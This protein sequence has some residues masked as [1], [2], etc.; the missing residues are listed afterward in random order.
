M[1][2]APG[3]PQ[4]EYRFQRMKDV[5]QK[6]DPL[7]ASAAQAT[8]RRQSASAEWTERTESG[9]ARSRSFNV[10]E[11]RFSVRSSAEEP[12]S[13]IEED[14]KFFATKEPGHGVVIELIAE[15]PPLDTVPASDAVV[16]TPRNVVYREGGKRFIDYHRRALAIQNEATGDLRIYS[17]DNGML[18]EAAYLYLLSQIGQRLDAAGLHRIHA[19]GLVVKRRAVLVMLPMGG[20]K[21]TLGLQLL[22]HP[23]VELLSDDAPFVDRRGRLLACPLRLGLLPGSEKTIPAE[24]RR[25]IQRMEFGPKH[26]VNYS[27]FSSRVCPSAEPGRCSLAHAPWPHPAGSKRSAVSP[28]CEPV[29]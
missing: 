14:F 12:L 26:L 11:Y 4:S 9:T 18:Y 22:Q 21:S 3:L 25:T 24:Q 15:A 23:Q 28:P 27:Y 20:G 8:D 19:L 1:Y 7:P 17:Q 2:K 10:Y 6:L 29:W 16:Y 5:A 13:G